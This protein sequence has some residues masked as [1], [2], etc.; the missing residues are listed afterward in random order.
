MTGEHG[1]P[2]VLVDRTDLYMSCDNEYAPL[3][4]SSLEFV[5][6][7]LCVQ[8]LYGIF[9]GTPICYLYNM[10]VLESN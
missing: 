2:T 5:Y 7:S 9:F 10:S 1:G 3:P 4:C 8:Q 6:W